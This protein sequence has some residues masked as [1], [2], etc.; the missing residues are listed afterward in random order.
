MLMVKAKCPCTLKWVHGAMEGT[1]SQATSGFCKVPR[2]PRGGLHTQA[3]V[4]A[5]GITVLLLQV[6]A[7]PVQ[8]PGVPEVFHQGLRQACGRHEVVTPV[9]V[10]IPAQAARLPGVDWRQLRGDAHPFG[11]AAAKAATASHR[12]MRW[13]SSKNAP[14][15]KNKYEFNKLQRKPEAVEVGG[16]PNGV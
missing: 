9:A 1:G 3:R 2:A 4:E 7:V 16:K 11:A 5:A 8:F 15:V 10:V 12:L 14:R 6:F 13:F